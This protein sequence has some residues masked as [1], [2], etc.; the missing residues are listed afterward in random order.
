MLLNAK[1]MTFI[2]KAT[3]ILTSFTH[4]TLRL[5]SLYSALNKNKLFPNIWSKNA[6]KNSKEVITFSKFYRA[7]IGVVAYIQK[8]YILSTIKTL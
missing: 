7:I 4:A 1:I 8:K 6:S 2:N 3:I 5:L